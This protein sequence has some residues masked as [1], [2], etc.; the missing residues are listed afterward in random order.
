MAVSFAE[1]SKRLEISTDELEKKSVLSFVAH[2]VRLA[3]NKNS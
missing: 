1:I 2:E 3:L